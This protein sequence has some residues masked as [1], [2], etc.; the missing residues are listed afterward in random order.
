MQAKS[1][2]IYL[3]MLWVLVLVFT[4]QGHADETRLDGMVEAVNAPYCNDG[5]APISKACYPLGHDLYLVQVTLPFRILT[6]T[7][8]FID[9]HSMQRVRLVKS[10]SRSDRDS[11]AAAARRVAATGAQD[12]VLQMVTNHNSG[13]SQAAI[14]TVSS[15]DCN[16]LRGDQ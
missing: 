13:A 7:D 2:S 6:F 11:F 5:E 15:A 1:F 8:S 9:C 12:A 16:A 4:S 10:T 14:S 3:A